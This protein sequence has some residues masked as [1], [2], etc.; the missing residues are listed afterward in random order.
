MCKFTSKKRSNKRRTVCIKV[1][2]VGVE[3]R[4]V[5]ETMQLVVVAI[6]HELLIMSTIRLNNK[7]KNKKANPI[8][9]FASF[10]RKVR[11]C[12]IL[13]RQSQ[14]SN[15]SNHV[16][17]GAEL[18]KIWPSEDNCIKLRD[19]FAHH[20]SRCEFLSPLCENFAHLKSTCE[21]GT[22]TCEF[23]PVSADSTRD[24]FF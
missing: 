19:N 24:L 15:G 6:V 11:A 14:E 22:P 12:L 5:L 8:A 2:I 3:P 16:R 1:A 4:S 7:C 17:F 13:V 21:I 20:C 18:R 23:S 10:E 9:R